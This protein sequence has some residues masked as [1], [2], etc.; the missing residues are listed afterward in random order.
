[1]KLEFAEIRSFRPSNVD[2][3]QGFLYWGVRG[4]GGN[5]SE[6]AHQPKICSSPPPGKIPSPNFYLLPTKSQFPPLNKIFQVITQ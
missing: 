1:M 5:R 3:F 4:G 6:T 2:T